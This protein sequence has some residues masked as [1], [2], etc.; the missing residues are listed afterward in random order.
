MNTLDSEDVA[1]AEPVDDELVMPRLREDFDSFYRRERGPVEALAYVLSGSRT[2]AEELTQDAFID[3]FRRW[4]RI[5]DYEQPGAWIRRA[6]AN[7]A[8]SGFRRRSSE[9]RAVLRVGNRRATI[10]ELPESAEEIWTAL[11]TLPKR[12]AQ[13]IALHYLEDRPT[14]EIADILKCSIPTVKTHLQRGRQRLAELL[15]EELES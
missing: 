1:M 2:A 14:A 9:A 5:G 7:R 13:A 11:R 15:H 12:Q 6:V 8:V 4:N 3:A 10:A